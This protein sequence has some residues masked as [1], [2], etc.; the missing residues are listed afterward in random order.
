M[1]QFDHPNVIRLFGYVMLSEP[2][3]IV[4]ELAEHSLFDAVRQKTYASSTLFTWAYQVIDRNTFYTCSIFLALDYLIF[5]HK[6]VFE[7]ILQDNICVSFSR[8]VS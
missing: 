3:I 6:P 7:N 8:I 1:G 4:T 2:L 5:N